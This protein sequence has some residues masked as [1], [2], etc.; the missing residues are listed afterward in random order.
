MEE[1]RRLRR[2]GVSISAIAVLMNCDRKTVRK[3]LDPS[4]SQPTY[5]K[6]ASRRGKLNAFTS[7][8]ESRLRAGV[9]NA[10]VLLSELRERGYRGGYTILKDWLQP[11]REAARSVATRRFETPPGRQA[12]VDWGSIGAVELAPGSRQSLSAFVMTL[13]CCRALFAE[14]CLDEQLPTFLRAHEAAFEAL[15]GVPQELLYDQVRTVVLGYD[16]RGEPKWHPVFQDFARY[17][18][19]RPR[20]CQ[21]YRAQTKGKVE[22]G[23]RYLKGNFL[24]GR[25]A[26]SVED[27]RAQLRVW[28]RTVANARVHGTIHRI[29]R[30]AWEEERLHLQPLSARAPYPYVP[31]VTRRVAP[32]A[33]IN[34]GTSRYSVPWRY[35]GRDVRVR[36]VGE[37]LEVYHGG[38][39]I[40]RHRLS[41]ARYELQ[42]VPAHHQD[43]PYGPTANRRRPAPLI[44]VGADP[45]VEIRPLGA[46]EQLGRGGWPDADA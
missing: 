41:Q 13:G 21:P 2:E 32:D 40:A 6:R 39:P 18:G 26:R 37:Q 36:Q 20:L 22:S 35:A 25:Q 8:L 38:Q 12:Q 4:V 3:Y 43:M 10:V 24:C 33:Y 27:L 7:Y 17:W 46:Y 44:V 23:I 28:T 42:T 45:E 11:Q 29:V 5:R 34:Y 9:W 31:E 14:V 16:E 30:E 19:F 15:G 1:I